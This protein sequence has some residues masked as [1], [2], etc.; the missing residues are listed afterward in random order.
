MQIVIAALN[1]NCPAAL[2]LRKEGVQFELVLMKHEYSYSDLF[3]HLWKI[4]E[5]FI[6]LE[7]DIVPWPGALEKLRQC[8]RSYCSYEYPL[9]PNAMQAALGCVKIS[10]SVMKKYPLL[11]K[12]W[13]N[14]L[15]NQLDGRVC[16]ALLATF[17]ET[18]IHTPPFAH[19]K[20]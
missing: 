2:A 3:C 15:W 17:G 4:Q 13:D 19:V 9:A 1:G 20:L 8:G 16:T 5:S 6:S 12:L 18:H 11:W 14:V 7:H 10:D